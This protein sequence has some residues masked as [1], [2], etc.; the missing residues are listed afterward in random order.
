MNP[1]IAIISPNTLG[2]ISLRS[3]LWDLYNKIEV[4]TYISMDEFIKDSN[5]HFI[6][7][8]VSSEILFSHVDEFSLLKKQ[9]T[10]LSAGP[11]NRI[12]DAGYN[13][14]NVSQKEDELVGSLMNIQLIA[15]YGSD[16]AGNSFSRYGIKNDLSSRE[17]EVLYLMV[18]GKINKE[19]AEILKISVTTVIFHRNNIC[20]KL[21]TRSLGRLTIFA[22][23]S[24][25]IEINEI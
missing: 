18:K 16:D 22:V 3:I 25:I 9:T 14:L 7:F 23:L 17:K 12:K 2:N 1:C 11:N 5:R 8:F 4:C 6:H 15:R 24:G 20:E 10:V 13:V 21:K 19:I